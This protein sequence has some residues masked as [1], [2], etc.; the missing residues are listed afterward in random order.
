LTI[1]A[2]MIISA[3][4][5][6]TLT[7][8]RAVSVFKTESKEG[9]GH[10]HMREALPWWIFA[11]IGAV[12]GST[13]LTPMVSHYFDMP[14]GDEAVGVE[15]PSWM[16]WVVNSLAILPGLIAGGIIGKLIIHPVNYALSI[17]FKGFNIV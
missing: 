4:N 11:I 9:G 8:S 17:V 10:E 15:I 1:S 13:Y 6:M 3:I 5:A 14:L 2:S 12:L 16:P 7:P